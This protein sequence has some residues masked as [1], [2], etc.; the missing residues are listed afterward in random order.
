MTSWYSIL[1]CVSAVSVTNISINNENM[2]DNE[3]SFSFNI[4][5]FFFRSPYLY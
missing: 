3:K 1:F 4:I 5:S 2:V